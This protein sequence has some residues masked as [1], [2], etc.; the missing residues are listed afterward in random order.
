MVTYAEVL[1]Q[2]VKP[3]VS[4]FL[5]KRGLALSE[6]KTVVTNIGK[7]FDFLGH[8]VRK[9]GG[10]LL[11]KPSKEYQNFPVQSSQAYKEAA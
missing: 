10:K 2:R 11:I 3:V 9:Y 5:R 6:K 4:S 8:H 1:E 7:G